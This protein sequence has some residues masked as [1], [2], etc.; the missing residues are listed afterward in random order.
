MTPSGPLPVRSLLAGLLVA[1]AAAPAVATDYSWNN[2]AGGDWATAGNWG[3]PPGGVPGAGDN[4]TIAL[5][6]TYT[7]TL[8]GTQ[9]VNNVTLN[10]AGAQVGSFGGNFNLGG[11]MT[12]TAGNWSMGGLQGTPAVLTGGTITRGAGGIGTFTV[13]GDVRL[14]NTQVQGNALV[15]DRTSNPRLR[16]NGTAGLTPGSV[17]NF[18]PANQTYGSYSGITLESGGTLDNVTVNLGSNTTLGTVGGQSLTLGPN[19]LVAFNDPQAGHQAVVG[20]EFQDGNGGI[21]TLTNQGTI[22][23]IVGQLYVGRLF[24]TGNNP[25]NVNVT[26][27][28]LIESKGSIT[29]HANNFTNA[30]GATVRA[31]AGGGV[32]VFGR[33]SWVNNGTFEVTDGSSL[34]LGGLFTRDAIGTVVRTGT[35]TVGIYAGWMDNSGGTWAL[36][37]TTGTYRLYGDQIAS[38]GRIIGGAITAADGAKLEVRPHPGAYTGVDYCRLTGVA[39]GPGVLSFPATGGKVWLENGTTLAAGDTITLAGTD[40][41][42]AYFQTQ[43]VDGLTFVLTGNQSTLAVYDNNVLT[44]GPTTLVRKTGTGT[45]MLTGGLFSQTSGMNTAMVNLGTV[46]VEQGTLQVTNSSAFTFT[47]RGTVQVDAGAT[48]S[49]NVTTDGGTVQGGGTIAGAVT[50]TTFAGGANALRPGSAAAPG[51]LST[52]ALTLNAGTTLYARLNGS[53]PGT[54]HD[55]VAVTGAVDLGDAVLSLTLGGGYAPAAGDKLFILTKDGTDPI[56]GVFAGITNLSR[57]TVGGYTATVSYFGDSASGN[58]TNGNDVV[59][60]DFAPVPEPGPVLAVAG[61]AL[62]ARRVGRAVPDGNRGV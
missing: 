47:N 40:T 27:A 15:F 51:R 13:S 31:M 52:G 6:G 18:A 44:L 49:G 22:R 53:T 43:Q 36:N 17:V 11:T 23:A 28:G 16:L 24:D 25:S 19:A 39:V 7:V 5:A 57:V 32:F 37:A 60:Y 8:T 30:A 41:A 26:N 10:S 58:V 12:L 59:L 48:L 55:Q 38:S 35:N 42:V 46:R 56:Q 14:V 29:I 20:R 4:A 1:V 2:A 9:S 61:L 34:D 33:N 50:F 54:G 3:P 45:A 21:I 62:L